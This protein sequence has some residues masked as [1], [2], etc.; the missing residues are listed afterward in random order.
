MTIRVMKIKI[1]SISISKED[2]KW[3]KLQEYLKDVEE[4]K[5]DYI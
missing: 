5:D 3:D 4:E 1:P 2:S